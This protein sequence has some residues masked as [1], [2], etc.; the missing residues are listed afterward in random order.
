[1]ANKYDILILY[2]YYDERFISHCVCLGSNIIECI[3]KKFT[4]DEFSEVSVTQN[5][6]PKVRISSVI[7]SRLKYYQTLGASMFGLGLPGI[8]YDNYR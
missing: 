3:E 2:L 6:D 4:N 8:G 5:S 1:M 7:P